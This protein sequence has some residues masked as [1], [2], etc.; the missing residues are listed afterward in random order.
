MCIAIVGAGYW[1]KNLIREFY[2][3]NVLDMVIEQDENLLNEIKNN[4]N[5][6]TSSNIQDVLNKNYITGIVI[7][8]PSET[9]YTIAKQCLDRNKNI[10]IEK[11]FTLDYN[12]SLELHN[13]SI[14]KNLK[15]MVGHILHY[16]L[17][18]IK[19]KSLLK[20][21]T[22][23][24]IKSIVTNRFSYGKIRSNE[25]VL[26]SFAPHDISLIYSL[27]KNSSNQEPLLNIKY[28]DSKT[29]CS[30]ISES[31]IFL[32]S[33]NIKVNINVSWLKPYKES[34]ITIVGT[35]GILYFDDVKKTLS[36]TKY[37]LLKQNILINDY[38]TPLKNECLH[39]VNCLI[40]NK[41][42]YT[43]SFEALYGIRLI[44]NIINHN[45][46]NLDPISISE[47]NNPINSNDYYLDS[48]SI[49][50]N[51][52][53]IGKNTKIWHYTHVC[54]SS[55]IGQNCN[56]GQNCYIG[57]NTIIG[58]Y[59][60]IQNNVSVYDGV[61]C[62]DYVFLGPSCVFTN[63]LNPRVEYP[64]NSYKK[65]Y[66]KYGATIGANATILCDLT[67]GRYALIGAGSVVVRD[68][69]EYAVM[70][71]NPAKQIGIIDKYGKI[72]KI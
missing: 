53:T 6:K 58:N 72:T 63:D 69:P 25:N 67:I 9:H 66:I 56:I 40:N 17:Y 1:G 20:N 14:Q 29:H 22:I 11:P 62:E 47:H 60:K 48:T 57:K 19:L 55:I 34:S 64:K 71:G 5:I 27:L 12:K 13:L 37:N 31:N 21:N 2:N 18:I 50:D 3:L 45:N 39:F 36:L 61:I 68:V 32:E 7:A 44:E 35:K 28:I 8:T 54:E 4:Y 30:N 41:I 42:P 38:I 52:T 59:C 70:V 65:T 49:I 51:N 46:Y 33:N 43:N 24:Q 10:F 15:I 16:N 23:G 26:W